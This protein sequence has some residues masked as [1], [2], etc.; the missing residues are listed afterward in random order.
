ME[1]KWSELSADEKQKV[2]FDRWLSPR[3]VDF[4]SPEAEVLYK[5]RVQR[6]IDVITLKEPDRVPVITPAGYIPAHYCGYTIKEAMYEPEK[7]VRAW[8]KYTRDFDH[9]VIPNARFLRCGKALDILG[10][11]GLRWAG[12]GLPDDCDAQVVEIENLKADEY[13]LY[14]KDR[15]DYQI[16]CNLPRTYR[17][18]EPLSKLPTLSTIG[19]GNAVF[20]DPDIQTAF[21]A[22]GEA[23]KAESAWN[24]MINSINRSAMA[25]G[26]PG[27]S[28]AFGGGSPFDRIGAMRGTIGTAKDMFKQSEKLITFMEDAVSSMLKQIA[29]TAEM[30]GPPIAFIALHRGA[31]GW[32]SEAQFLS[33]YWPYLK[34]VILGY[35]EEGIVPNLFAEGGYNTRLEI[36]KELPAGKVIWHFDKTDIIRAKEILGDRACIMGN[37]P[38]SILIAGTSEEVK[39]HCKQLIETVGKGGGYILS[40]GATPNQSKIENIKGMMDSAK[41]YGVYRK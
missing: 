41:E 5:V 1:K 31:D 26:I 20:A 28:Q 32:M 39:N 29:I 36:I 25:S 23:G 2:R 17:A 37:V 35:I 7:I 15:S 12:N 8:E 3:D 19:G 34:K 6:F 38:S 27:F 9:D 11:K 30:T 18:A 33:F 40:Y 14:L 10:H 13:D 4:V 24:K 16:R 22:L 21:K